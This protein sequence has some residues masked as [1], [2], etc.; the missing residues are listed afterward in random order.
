MAKNIYPITM[1]LSLE[2][3]ANPRYSDLDQNEL[4]HSDTDRHGWGR[5]IGGDLGDLYFDGYDVIGGRTYL[6]SPAVL[7]NAIDHTWTEDE[8]Y[9]LAVDILSNSFSSIGLECVEHS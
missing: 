9:N 6:R 1:T 5:V 4:K 3:V 7:S 2:G 8:I